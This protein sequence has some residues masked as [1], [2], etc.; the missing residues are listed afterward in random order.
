MPLEETNIKLSA[1]S[2]SLKNIHFRDSF[3][4]THPVSL[5]AT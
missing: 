1:L 5:L 3:Q 4:Q 2:L